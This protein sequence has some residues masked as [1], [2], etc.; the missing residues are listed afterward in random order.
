MITATGLR[1]SVSD[2]KDLFEMSWLDSTSV[3]YL[4]VAEPVVSTALSEVFEA[5][6]IIVVGRLK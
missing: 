1:Q 4:P 5:E 6:G 3:P 2:I